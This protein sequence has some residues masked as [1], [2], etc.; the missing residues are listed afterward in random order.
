MTDTMGP[1][2]WV[3][4][5]WEGQRPDGAV[6]APYIIELVERGIVRLI[7]IAFVAKDADGEITAVDLDT[8]DVDSPLGQFAGASSGL[9]GHED[10]VEAAAELAPDSAAAVIVW[11]NRWVVPFAD[12]LRESGGSLIGRGRIDY[13]DLVA[14]LDALEA[15]H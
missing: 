8:I 12:K 1:I 3:V 13:D 14:T 5:E 6:L 4:I 11:E 7:D 15:V 9:L 2:D 10:V